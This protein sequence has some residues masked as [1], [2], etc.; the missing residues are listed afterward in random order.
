MG[1]ATILF[2][3]PLLAAAIL[4]RP[5]A[6]PQKLAALALLFVGVG[7][8]TAPAWLHNTLVAR[9]PVFLSAHS[10]VNFWIGNNPAATGYPSFPAGLRAGQ[11]EMLADSIA[12]AEAAAG[13]PLKRSEVS[14]YWSAKARQSIAEN[15]A[16][17]SGLLWKKVSNFWNAF[18]YDDVGVLTSMREQNVTLPGIRFGFI[19]ALALPGMVIAAATFPASRWIM[20]AVF[21]HLLSL[22]SV[23]ITE[24]YR[25]AAVPGL[26]LFGSFLLWKIWMLAACRRVGPLLGVLG[27]LAASTWFVTLPRNDPGPWAL[28]AYNSGVHALEAR[29][30]ALARRRLELADAYV[31]ENPE[32]I[33]ALGNVDLAQGDRAS[34]AA[35]YHQTLTLNP[36]HEGALNNLGVMALED[37]QWEAARSFLQRAVAI[38]PTKA[39]TRFLLAQCLLETGAPGPA[40]TEAEAALALEPARPEFLRLR[41]RILQT[42]QP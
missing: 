10:G 1:I 5:K 8:G 6:L 25:L 3:L 34:A 7:L 19:A 20:A 14:A 21:L 13:R 23:F 18:Q 36:R 16:A 32:V 39:K 31:P 42:F 37:S 33:F 15:P 17:W 29:D 9:D 11:K 4:Y 28:D 22:L 40:L 27:A 30:P 35:R 24:R 26:L 12:S 38:D 41:E 2:T